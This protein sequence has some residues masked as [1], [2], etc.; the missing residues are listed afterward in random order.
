MNDD[1]S[2]LETPAPADPTSAPAAGP[3][4][5]G[6][7]KVRFRDRVIGMRGVAAVALA[8]LILGGAGGFALGAVSNGADGSTGPG[9]RG[10]PGGNFQ[11][12][13]FPGGQQGQ[14]PGGQ[15]G[16]PGGAPPADGRPPGTAP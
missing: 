6:E 8:S 15:Q 13:Q 14:F 5:A 3:D 4:A 2:T 16:G 9:G 10:G 1:I 7:Q 11:Q 12:G